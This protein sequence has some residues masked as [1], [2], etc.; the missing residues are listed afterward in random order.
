MIKT[1]ELEGVP[2]GKIELGITVNFNLE[3][4]PELTNL[5]SGWMKIKIIQGRDLVAADL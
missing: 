4:I 1:Y 3:P 2:H 5:P